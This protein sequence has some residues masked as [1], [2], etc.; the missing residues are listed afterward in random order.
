[1]FQSIVIFAIV[2]VILITFY[3]IGKTTAGKSN[4]NTSFEHIHNGLV[5]SKLYLFIGGLFVLVV[6]E[7]NNIA[8]YVELYM[9]VP[10]PETF[11]FIFGMVSVVAVSLGA[12]RIKKIAADKELSNRDISEI[13]G[14]FLLGISADIVFLYYG[15]NVHVQYYIINLNQLQSDFIKYQDPVFGYTQKELYQVLR[16]I[17]AGIS[18]LSIQRW[19]GYYRFIALMLQVGLS[20]IL[21]YATTFGY[22]YSQVKEIAKEEK[23]EEDKDK[24]EEEK[25]EE[26][27]ADGGGWMKPKSGNPFRRK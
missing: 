9:K 7:V 27:P 10:N 8:Y 23:N 22:G 24:K 1:M 26:I 2:A 17:Q 5:R 18:K 19:E 6:T 3:I 12:V 25:D 21:N 20:I 14:Y 4:D 15:Y 16:N 11:L 13:L